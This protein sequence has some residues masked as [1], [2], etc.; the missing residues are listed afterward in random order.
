MKKLLL[1]ILFF[2][3]YQTNAQQNL[4]LNP[5]FEDLNSNMNCGTSLGIN[6]TVTDWISGSQGT[7]DVVSSFF[8][9]S[10]PLGV[11]NVFDFNQTPRTGNNCVGAMSVFSNIEGNKY[12]EY[13]KGRLSQ[14]LLPG[15]IY[16]IELYVC[17][18]SENKGSVGT[19]NIGLKFINDNQPN[20]ATFQIIQEIPDV[21]YSGPAIIDRE[22][23]TL[24]SF[25]YTPTT[26]GLN[27][28]LIGN[29][30]EDQNTNIQF[31]D[32]VNYKVNYLLYDDINIYVLIPIFN[33]SET[34][35]QGDEIILS[36]I[37]DNGVTGTWSPAPNNQQTTT[38]TFTP[39]NPLLE[40]IQKTIIVKPRLIP[41]FLT[42]GPYC[43]VL[44]D[45]T[46]LPTTSINGIDGTWSPTFDPTQTTTYTFIT[47]D[48]QCIEPI[49][50]TVIVDKTPIFDAVSP[51]C[52]IDLNFKL[53]IVSSNGI[54]G[55]WTPKF[56]P[57]NSQTYTF[58]R[59]SGNCTQEVT[60]DVIVHPQLIFE[61]HHFCDNQKYIVEIV[62]NNF[63]FS[64]ISNIQWKINNSIIQKFDSKINLIDYLNLINDSN[65]IEFS[66][67]DANGCEY[68]KQI[69]INGNNLCKIQKGISPNGDGLN[70]YLDL[71]FFGSV[72]IK[73]FN[74]YGNVV[75]ENSN[76][77]NEWYGQSKN[78]KNL[79][80]GTYF[81][82]IQTN[83]GEQF[84]G[85]IQL[86]Y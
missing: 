41:E 14:N 19:N 67:T 1:L 44:P 68:I 20:Y 17:V 71:A 37:S 9:I 84:T 11:F 82:Q 38:Y 7:P 53:P 8:D 24:L 61:I 35:C 40:Q 32:Q 12:R 81:Y 63:S 13:L 59:D 26:T 52:D 39:D 70:E 76:Y 72:D 51:F 85:Y 47:N 56:D 60:L 34:I 15:I 45:F 75:Y 62:S 5:S 43:D 54:S 16:Q 10:C 18:A 6:Y 25:S 21:N 29:F 23:W 66:F 33:F 30:F 46:N 80:S 50:I 69:E 74:R 48:S 36:N 57:Y 58:T 28:F 73:I 3:L 77:K 49:Q 83:I 65:I 22:N 64:D 2:C 55:T 31:I 27:A 79:P 4:V 86:T 78:G 42:Y